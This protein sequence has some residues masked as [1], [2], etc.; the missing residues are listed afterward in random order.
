VSSAKDIDPITS[1]KKFVLLLAYT[2]RN[3]DRVN[4]RHAVN[5]FEAILE[6]SNKGGISDEELAQQFKY[7]QSEIR[8]VLHILY[9]NGIAKFRRGKHPQHGATRYYWFIDI[10]QVNRVLLARKKG[11]LERLKRRLE[12]EKNNEF[13][14]CPSERRRN[15]TVKRYTFDE[16]YNYGFICPETGEPMEMFDNERYIRF[17]ESLIQSLEEEIKED[18]RALQGS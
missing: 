11:V 13:Y 16:A 8:R 9:D 14:Y 18:E 6:A 12:Y 5:I 15:G 2:R 7:S 1:L 10:S 3:I 4:P 17:L